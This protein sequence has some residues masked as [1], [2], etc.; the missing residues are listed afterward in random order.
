M[1]KGVSR[2]LQSAGVEISSDLHFFRFVFP[3][4]IGFRMGYRPV[5]KHYFSDLLFSVNLSD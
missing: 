1:T 2:K 3:M 4:D 5:E